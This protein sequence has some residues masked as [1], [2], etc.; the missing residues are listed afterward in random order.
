MSLFVF[1]MISPII[2]SPALQP[3]PSPSPTPPPSFAACQVTVEISC[4]TVAAPQDPCESITPVN[5]LACS[6][7]PTQLC[8][9]YTGEACGDPTQVGMN[10][11]TGCQDMASELEDIVNLVIRDEQGTNDI[12][13]EEIV[14]VG[15]PFCIEDTGG[16]PDQLIVG[17]QNRD[18]AGGQIVSLDATCQE[19]GLL[20]NEMYGSL[21]LIGF[22]TAEAGEVNCLV[23]VTYQYTVTNMGVDSIVMTEFDRTF[24]G[25]SFDIL[26][27]IPP[28]PPR[29]IGVETN[30][31]Y[32][33][34]GE[35]NRCV[36]TSVTITSSVTANGPEDSSTCMDDDLYELNIPGGV[37]PN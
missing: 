20:L 1:A 12:L 28:G 31:M 14:R 5:N 35:V 7:A 29:V 22:T 4:E 32:R 6:G 13:F 24:N 21:Q 37:Q 10:G 34:S 27:E 23:G 36:D 25:Q 30:F 16:L 18:N 26:T 19:N 15:D 17:V 33:Q 3:Q 9:E 2:R 11:L 8:F